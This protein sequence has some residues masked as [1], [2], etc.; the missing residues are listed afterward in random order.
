MRASCF[1]GLMPGAVEMHRGG[2]ST[3]LA[4]QSACSLCGRVLPSCE[5]M[6]IASNRH[7]GSHSRGVTALLL[8]RSPDA[9]RSSCSENGRNKRCQELRV[10]SRPGWP[11]AG[12]RDGCCQKVYVWALQ[13]LGHRFHSASKLV[14]LNITAGKNY[15]T[16][17]G[18]HGMPLRCAV[19]LLPLRDPGKDC[20]AHTQPQE[21]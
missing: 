13:L 17:A 11:G 8:L 3:I 4:R 20:L 19:K 12:A 6:T 10:G 21:S 16:S 1:S 2:P 9:I 18:S 7:T 15:V 5:R 14:I